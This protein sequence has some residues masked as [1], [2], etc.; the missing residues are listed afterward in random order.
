MTAA[1]RGI[2]LVTGANGGMGRHCARMLGASNDLVL[3]DL[4]ADPLA[5]FAGTLAEEGYT[6]AAQVAGDLSDPTLL[7]RLVEAVGGRLDVLVHAAGLSPAQAGWRRIL[8]VNL[9]ATDLLLT[10]LAPAMRP[11]SV[12]V[13]IASMAGHMAAELPQAAELL[14]HANAPGVADRMAAL[15]ASSGMSE[16]QSA[17]MVYALSK[18]AVI[19]LAERKAAEWP[20]AR[21]VSLSPGLI[22]TPMGRLEGEDAQTAVIREAMP[23]KRWGTGMDIAAAVAFLVSPAASFITGCDLRIDGGAIAGLRAMQALKAETGNGR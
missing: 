15:L 5:A 8:Q 13:L 21:V 7:A 18:Q 2:A 9:V 20:Q 4:A 23:I 3:T 17:G 14:E 10:A 11:G 6:V 16:A 22:A 1:T 19:R 12:A